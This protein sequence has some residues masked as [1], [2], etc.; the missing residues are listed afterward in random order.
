MSYQMVPVICTAS[1]FANNSTTTCAD[2][3]IS[4][5]FYRGSNGF[6]KKTI[7]G[8]PTFSRGWDVQL[9]IPIETYRICDFTGWS[10][11]RPLTPGSAHWHSG[12]FGHQRVSVLLCIIHVQ[13]TP[14]LPDLNTTL[15]SF[16][17]GFEQWLPS[18][19]TFSGH[20]WLFAGGPNR[21]CVYAKYAAAY[22][23]F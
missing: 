15:A 18:K 23:N 17:S 4:P 16:D 5:I 7:T 19:H 22:F 2:P 13:T 14:E 11:P 12:Y 6:P 3:A 8:G 21:A 20:S 10:G 1:V 9:L